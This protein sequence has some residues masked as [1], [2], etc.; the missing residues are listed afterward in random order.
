MP[1]GGRNSG[2]VVATMPG[3]RHD[4]ERHLRAALGD[5]PQ[6]I[7]RGRIGPVQIL[8]SQYQ[9]LRLGTGHDPVGQHRQ[10]PAAQFLGRQWRYA[11]LGQRNIKKRREQGSV[12]RGIELD[13]GKRVFQVRQPPFRRQVSAAEALPAP[14]SDWVQ[15]RVLQKLR[16]APLHPG[17]R[18]VGE[19]G[20]EFLN[21]ARFAQARFADDQRQL[22][23]APTRPLPAPHQHGDFLVTAHK[24]GEIPLSGTAPATTGAD[25]PEQGRRFGHPFERMRAAL[26]R[27]K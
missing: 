2:R 15:R 21:Q 22:A 14:F 24:R 10:L 12:F 26:F 7:E 19:P 6:H 5:A 9:R 18:G 13:L 25:E 20:V 27:N 8:E 17:V 23:L 11:F 16:A 4:I 3:R 1:Q